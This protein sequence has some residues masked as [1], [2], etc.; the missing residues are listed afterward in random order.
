MQE[1]RRLSNM[2][3]N[4]EEIIQIKK[5]TY[6]AIRILVSIFILYLQKKGRDC[7]PKKSAK[8]NEDR[9][10]EKDRKNEEDIEKPG[11]QLLKLT[12]NV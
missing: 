6:Q 7:D 2:H 1:F 10:N 9:K 3:S 11:K 8:A 5:V 12:K 4:K